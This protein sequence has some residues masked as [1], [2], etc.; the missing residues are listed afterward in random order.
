MKGRE[1]VSKSARFLVSRIFVSVA[2]LTIANTS[3]A[4]K[5]HS[6]VVSE[7]QTLQQIVEDELQSDRFA[8]QIAIYNGYEAGSTIIPIGATIKIPEPYMRL[9]NYG[10]VVFAKGDVVH[11]QPAIVVNPPVKGAYVHEG[12]IFTTGEDGFVSLKFGSGSVVNVQPDSRISVKDIACAEEQD[13]CVISLDA[14]RGEIE[15][16]VTPRPDGQPPVEFTVT[17]P[18]LSAAVRGT[19][20]YVS[21]E[22]GADRIGVTSGLVATDVAGTT[23]DLPKGKGLLAEANVEPALVDLLAA[24]ELLS[25]EGANTFSVEDSVRWKT[26]QAAQQYRLTVARDE[27]LTTPLL[28]EVVQETDA[29]TSWDLTAGDYYMSVAGIDDNQFLGLPVVKQFTFADITDQEKLELQVSRSN[30]VTSI[31]PIEY[32]GLVE[33]LIS[34]SLDNPTEERRVTR[35]LSEGLSLDLSIT[36]DWVIRARKALSPTTVSVYSDYYVLEAEN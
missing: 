19:T 31:G 1:K 15:S 7:E 36:Q 27:A 13:S 23:N 21:V 8:R 32:A 18:F 26:L 33:L 22:K 10:Q 28:S 29:L 12:D 9:R 2:L 25:T 11:A 6:I 34:N 4:E 30:A 5:D 3:V 17:T 24:P 35:N 20:F 16:Q 14:E